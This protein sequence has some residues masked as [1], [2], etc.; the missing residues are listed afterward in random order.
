M[1]LGENLFFSAVLIVVLDQK[2]K[3]CDQRSARSHNQ[4]GQRSAIDKNKWS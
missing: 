2:P 1:K 4:I 3:Q